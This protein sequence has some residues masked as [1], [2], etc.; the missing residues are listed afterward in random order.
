VIIRRQ[1][2]CCVGRDNEV[3]IRT[4]KGRLHWTK[5]LRSETTSLSIRAAMLRR[6]VVASGPC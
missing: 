4:V 3:N 6:A 5:V 1:S 2:M